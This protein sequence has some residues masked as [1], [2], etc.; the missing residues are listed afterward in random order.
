MQRAQALR[1]KAAIREAFPESEAL[2]FDYLLST[3]ECNEKDRHVLAAAI[4]SSANIVTFNL[5]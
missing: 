2:P 5:K 4:V 3:L 1:R